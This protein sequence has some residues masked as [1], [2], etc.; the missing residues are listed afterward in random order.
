M[1]VLGRR[2]EEL[3]LG[4][5]IGPL[6]RIHTD[7]GPNHPHIGASLQLLHAHPH[8]VGVEHGYALQP[9]GIRLAELGDPLIIRLKHRV[10]QL[11]ILHVVQRKPHRGVYDAHVDA[12]EVHGVDVLLW[13]VTTRSNV[14]EGSTGAQLARVIE[15]G[16][17]LAT[18]GPTTTRSFDAVAEPPVASILHPHEVGRSVAVP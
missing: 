7:H 18:S 15:P 16:A 2:P 10:Q 8:I 17:Y 9:M 4:G 14:F 1:E 13:D 5:V 3:V 12:V 6:L 11:P